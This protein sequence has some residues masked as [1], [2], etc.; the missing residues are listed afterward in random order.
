[1]TGCHAWSIVG[2]PFFAVPHADCTIFVKVE[3]PTC[4]INHM[5]KVSTKLHLTAQTMPPWPLEKEEE[6]NQKY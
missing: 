3:L 6:T 2:V 1:M 4:Q 5:T